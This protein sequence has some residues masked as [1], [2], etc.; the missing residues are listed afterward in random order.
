MSFKARIVHALLAAALSVVTAVPV[1]W[2][3]PSQPTGLGLD[4]RIVQRISTAL[5]G[6]TKP[7]DDADIN[8]DGTVDILDFQCAVNQATGAASR[9]KM[10]E[11]PKPLGPL[12]PQS[13]PNHELLV[14]KASAQALIQLPTPS[15]PTDT[16]PA[17]PQAHTPKDVLARLGLLAHAPPRC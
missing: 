3:N 15:V 12:V 10:D 5:L 9:D 4:V 1:S 6:N 14:L 7:L 8:H 17:A 13:I 2:C 16:A 11:S